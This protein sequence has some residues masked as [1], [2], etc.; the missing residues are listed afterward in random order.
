MGLGVGGQLLGGYLGAAPQWE[1]PECTGTTPGV[2]T[3]GLLLRHTGDALQLHQ[4][5]SN[6]RITNSDTWKR[7]SYGALGLYLKDAPQILPVLRGYSQDTPQILYSGDTHRIPH[8]SCTQGILIGYPTDPVLRGYSQDTPHILPVLRGYSQDTPHILNSGDTHRI[9]HRSCLYS[10]DTH[11]YPTHPPCTQEILTGH[12]T[13]PVLRGYSQDTPLIL[14]VLR[15]YSQDTPHI[16]PVLRG[17]SQDTPHILPVLR[18]YTTTTPELLLKHSG[19]TWAPSLPPHTLSFSGPQTRATHGILRIYSAPPSQL[20][21]GPFNTPP[22]RSA[23]PWVP[24]GTQLGEAMGQLG[25]LTACR[26]TGGVQ[27][28]LL[29]VYSWHAPGAARQLQVTPGMQWGGITAALTPHTGQMGGARNM[30]G[31]WGTGDRGGGQMGAILRSYATDTQRMQL[32]TKPRQQETEAAPQ[33][34]AAAPGSQLAAAYSHLT[35]SLLPGYSEVTQRK[36]K[37]YSM[38]TQRL[39]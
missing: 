18:L 35:P 39:L 26:G 14:P 36:C 16:L 15:G 3:P 28:M 13:D 34:P 37:G 2:N 25:G 30:G 4:E 33:S 20:Y 8:R 24:H 19:D 29:Q 31:G 11:R 5:R 27:P 32:S 7:G 6:A 38:V 1:D 10:G 9:P 22:R 12:P 17:Y 21:S 23:T